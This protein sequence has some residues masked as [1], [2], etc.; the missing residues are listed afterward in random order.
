VKDTAN[1]YISPQ[2]GKLRASGVSGAGS[3]EGVGGIESIEGI[4]GIAD[5]AGAGDVD[6]GLEAAKKQRERET[7]E[8]GR[9]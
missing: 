6:S 8:Q 5:L 1:S 2:V 9:K 7:K 4:E 3:F